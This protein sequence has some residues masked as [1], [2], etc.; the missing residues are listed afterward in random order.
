M[1]L[2]FLYCLLDLVRGTNRVE[3]ADPTIWDASYVQTAI[4]LLRSGA[5][6]MANEILI[7]S[8]SRSSDN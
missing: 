5:M 8:W 7:Q 6:L 2:T 4:P 1:L 3:D